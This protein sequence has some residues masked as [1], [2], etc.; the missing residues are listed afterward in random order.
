[1]D[2]PPKAWFLYVLETADGS[3][4]TGITTDL[5]RRVQQHNT[6]KGAKYT[7]LRCPVRLIAA[8]ETAG[9]ASATQLEL[10]FKKLSRP[11]KLALAASDQ[12][13]KDAVKVR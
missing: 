8:W 6:G 7:A 10:A 3:L 12:P 4:Y 11:R 9:R 1:M 2:A 13:F 5:E